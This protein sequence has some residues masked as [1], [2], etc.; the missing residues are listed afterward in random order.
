MDFNPPETIKSAQTYP[1]E[2]ENIQPTKFETET[3]IL[4]F[5][6]RITGKVFT[7][8]NNMASVVGDM[9]IPPRTS[10]NKT[11]VVK[12]T[13]R[14]GENCEVRG[15]LKAQNIHVGANT[16][17]DGDVISGE[18]AL[19]GSGVIITGRLQAG[20]HIRIGEQAT[21]KQGSDPDPTAEMDNN[22]QLEANIGNIVDS[23]AHETRKAK[24]AKSS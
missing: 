13:L 2:E 12:G 18:N 14:I 20:G 22:I 8:D 1:K 19:F 24:S 16:I 9:E 23:I 7:E 10:V 5:P 15:K 21:I 3:M 6:A 4:G 11:L 17:I